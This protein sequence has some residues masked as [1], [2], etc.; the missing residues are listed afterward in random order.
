MELRTYSIGRLALVVTSPGVLGGWSSPHGG[1]EEATPA[2]SGSGI[3][4]APAVDNL[5]VDTSWRLIEFQSMDDSIGGIR[6]PIRR[7]TR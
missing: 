3:A 4:E 6:P 1:P 5:L 7:F 2:E